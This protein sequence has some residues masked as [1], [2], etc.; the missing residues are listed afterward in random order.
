MPADVAKKLGAEVVISVNLGRENETNQ[1]IKKSLDELYPEN[2]VKLGIRSLGCYNYSD[3]VIEPDLEKFKSGVVG[4]FD[5]IYKIGYEVAKER[6]AE[7]KRLI[8]G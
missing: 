7:I 6:M 2:K 1:V 3:L 5:E 4:N 8:K